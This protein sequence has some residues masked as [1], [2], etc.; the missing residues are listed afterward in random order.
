ML[1]HDF[2]PDVHGYVSASRGYKAGGINPGGGTVPTFDPEFIDAGEIGL[3]ATALDGSLQLNSAAFYYDYSDLQIGQ[4][5]VTSA[6][7]VNTDAEVY[8]GEFEWIVRPRESRFQF[9]GS[10]SLL[11]TRIKG[12][13]SG[14]EGD[15]NAIAPGAVIVRDAAGN[16]VRNGSG[17]II[18]NLDG[19]PLP[20]SPG[21]KI[22]LGMQYKFP[23]GTMTLTPRLDH[24]QQ[25]NYSGTAFDKPIDRF[26]GYSQTDLK[27]LLEPEGRAWSIRGYVKNL[28]NKDDVTRMSQEGPLV[29]RFRSLIILEPRTYGVEATY[30]F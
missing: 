7:T 4:V 6:N 21:W 25:S 18:K 17:V 27:L 9:D 2:S 15:P 23:L 19:N 14:D 22:A 29:G 3:K 1:D 24:Y 26:E 20:F 8:G 16:P 30:R 10:L 13:Q 12:F 11:K 28:F 5:G